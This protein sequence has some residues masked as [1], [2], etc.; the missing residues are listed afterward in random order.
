MNIL[1]FCI[2]IFDITVVADGDAGVVVA[3][4]GEYA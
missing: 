4:D 2:S 1:F 3:D